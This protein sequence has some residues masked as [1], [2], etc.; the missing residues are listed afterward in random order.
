MD[1]ADFLKTTAATSASPTVQENT[2]QELIATEISANSENPWQYIP[3]KKES[4]TWQAAGQR[5]HQ[6]RR[7]TNTLLGVASVDLSG[8]HVAT[9]MLGAT[10]DQASGYYF[11]VMSVHPDKG[12]SEEG[13]E[14]QQ[15]DERKR[16]LLHVEVLRRK[17]DTRY[18]VKRLLAGVRDDHRYIPPGVLLRCHSDKGSEFLNEKMEEVLGDLSIRQTTTQGFDPWANGA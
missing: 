14:S 13:D 7:R 15:E 17:A 4:A 3:Y 5:R 8:P 11:L 9:P 16:P 12:P 1:S 18:A 10:L 2:V 6:H